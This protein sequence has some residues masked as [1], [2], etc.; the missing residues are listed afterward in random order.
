MLCTFYL[1]NS[2]IDLFVL[3]HVIFVTNIRGPVGIHAVFNKEIGF[4]CD[5]TDSLQLAAEAT[6]IYESVLARFYELN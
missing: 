4:W 2:Y 5:V 3:L 6:T 1:I